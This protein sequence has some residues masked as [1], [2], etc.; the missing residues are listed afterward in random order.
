[1]KHDKKKQDAEGGG[2]EDEGG[3]EAQ[4]K[5]APTQ[6]GDQ[7]QTQQTQPPPPPPPPPPPAQ[8]KLPP[9]FGKISGAEIPLELL[10]RRDPILFFDDVVLYESELDDNGISLLSVKVRVHA[11]RMLLLSRLFMRLDGVV[12]R[13][14]DTRVYV[15]FEKE[16]VLREYTARE[17]KFDV[18]KRV[19]GE[20]FFFLCWG[21]APCV[22]SMV[23]SCL[24]GILTLHTKSYSSVYTCAQCC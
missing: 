10:K 8:G 11:Q 13:I 18:V 14:R 22:A 20:R 17:G 19:R 7:Q 16:E 4:E 9:R 23:V 12:V 2:T 21:W 15:D 24:L 5:T 3:E 6:E 1:M